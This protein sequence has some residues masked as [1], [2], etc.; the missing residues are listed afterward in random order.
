[1]SDLVRQFPDA[2]S[3]GPKSPP[4]LLCMLEEV[5]DALNRRRPQVGRPGEAAIIADADRLRACAL[6]RIALLRRTADARS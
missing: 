1:M 3:R 6:R 4:D 5:V 2:V